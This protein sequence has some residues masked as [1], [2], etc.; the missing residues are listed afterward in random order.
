MLAEA[1]KKS[2][3]SGYQEMMVDVYLKAIVMRDIKRH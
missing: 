2:S 1:I 3:C